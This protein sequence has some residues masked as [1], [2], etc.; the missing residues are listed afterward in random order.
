[1]D[2]AGVSDF[3]ALAAFTLWLGNGFSLPKNIGHPIVW[4]IFI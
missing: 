3:I 4:W 1:M 2:F